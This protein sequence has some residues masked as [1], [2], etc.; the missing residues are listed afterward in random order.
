[1]AERLPSLERIAAE[2]RLEREAHVRHLDA[3]DTKAGII[4]GFSGAVA[5]IG[6]RNASLA[7]AP[8]LALAIGAGL[9]A[10]SALLPQRFPTWDLPELRAYLG[11]E[12][13]FT[14]RRM[15]DTAIDMVEELKL[16]LEQKVQRLR[17]G[18]WL[19]GV[20][21]LAEAAG[22]LAT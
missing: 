20:A 13:E 3:V 4:L 10:L 16:C 19:L 1:M 11:A 17:I 18:V 2:V 9:V 12:I 21:V 5:A 15:L 14:E 8:G 22:T 7:G 6:S